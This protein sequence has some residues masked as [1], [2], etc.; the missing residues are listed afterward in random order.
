MT[1]LD[2]DPT[3]RY[4][5]T[6]STDTTIK[7]W[8]MEGRFCTHN[9]KGHGG[10]IQTV[11]FDEMDPFRLFTTSDDTTAR[12]WDLKRKKCIA[13]LKAHS[14]SVRAIDLDASGTLLMTAGRDQMVHLWSAVDYKL[15]SS[16]PV[17]ELIEA[18][19]FVPQEDVATMTGNAA[20]DAA[21]FW[22][23]GG[24]G[25]LKLWSAKTGTEQWTEKRDE[26]ATFE[27]VNAMYLSLLSLHFGRVSD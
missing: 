23:A 4:L 20:S 18:A 14:S 16:Y 1:T 17:F 13:V 24:Q 22:T 19:G 2:F 25:R 8:V 12:V 21:L 6:G 5:A 9:L 27:I 15:K 26:R 10:I 3:G 7:V 11:K